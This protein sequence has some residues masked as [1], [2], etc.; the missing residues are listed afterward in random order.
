MERKLATVRTITYLSP[1]EG[2]DKNIDGSYAVQ[3][4]GEDNILKFKEEERKAL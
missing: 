4:Y 2:A 3:V 1:I